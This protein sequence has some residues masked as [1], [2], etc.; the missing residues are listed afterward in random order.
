MN[1]ALHISPLLPLAYLVPLMAA[2]LLVVMLA[3][4]RKASGT[5]WRLVVFTALALALLNPSLVHERREPIRDV[6]LVVVDQSPSQKMGDREEIS[7]AA[8]QY[9][10]TQLDE[11]ADLDVRYAFVNSEGRVEDFARHGTRLF[12]SVYDAF[13]DV[14]RS[15]IAGVFL[16]TDGQVHDVPQELQ[17]LSDYGPVHTVLTGSRD[18]VDRHLSIVQAPNYGLVGD[19]VTFTLRVDDHGTKTPGGI[20][21]VNV[22]QDG[23]PVGRLMATPGREVQH[24]FR[25]R[26]GGENIFEFT[27]DELPNELTIANNK[28]A[29]VVNGVRDR[30]KVLLVSGEPHQGERTWRNLLKSD[31]A[32]D[33]VHFTILRPPDKYDATPTRELSLIA[34]PVRELFQ[35]KINDFDLIIFDRYKRRGVLL[36]AYFRN[37]ANYVRGGGALLIASGPDY[38]T[39]NSLYQTILQNI[40]PGRPVPNRLMVD[41]FRPAITDLGHRHPVTAGLDAQF[42]RNA[43]LD[44]EGPGPNWGRWFRQ[45]GVTAK[46]GVTVMDGMDN[47]PLLILDKVEDGRVAQLAS[48]Q[49]WLWSRGFEGGGPQAELLRRLAHWLMKEPEL[50][51]TDLKVRVSGERMIVRRRSLQADQSDVIMTTPDGERAVVTT[52]EQDQGWAVGEVMADEIGVYRFDY[53][54]KTTF[55]AVGALNSKELSAVQTTDEYLAPVAEYSGGRVTWFQ[56]EGDFDIR[57]TG[58]RETY[59]GSGWLGLRENGAY[60]VH[61]ITDLPLLPTALILL[62]GLGCLLMA[63]LREGRA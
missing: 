44:A 5:V 14:P 17:K 28:A 33:L 6:A 50:E 7:R 35:L 36:P 55:A 49:I 42:T 22:T 56:E 59:S 24:S 54:D 1:T 13:A 40:L 60:T 27:V 58:A 52:R 48:D 23:E 31:P 51:E 39:G 32:V 43:S 26:H 47:S 57:K 11:L 20:L 10:E 34:F 25:L 8:Q 19:N 41:G 2:A 12:D 3:A 18:E 16:I 46:S 30:L 62:L 38:V 21:Y 61:G 53:K 63:W 4:W 29:L 37:I 45:V 9:V 15:Q